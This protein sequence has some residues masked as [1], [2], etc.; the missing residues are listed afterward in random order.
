VTTLEA[1]AAGLAIPP[2]KKHK[3]K[4]PAE[5]AAFL[6]H[7]KGKAMNKVAIVPESQPEIASIDTTE[8]TTDAPEP[9]TDATEPTTDA[10]EAANDANEAVTDA[11]DADDDNQGSES[12]NETELA[13]TGV[14]N[15]EVDSQRGSDGGDGGDVDRRSGSEGGE[16]SDDPPND[17]PFRPSRRPTS[18]GSE[19]EDVTTA[20]SSSRR[21]TPTPRRATNRRRKTRATPS[22]VRTGP[23]D[24]ARDAGEKS[25]FI[26]AVRK[27][28]ADI[29]PHSPALPP[30]IYWNP[31]LTYSCA[32]KLIARTPELLEMSRQP[33]YDRPN[34]MAKKWGQVV[35]TAA[36]NERSAQIRVIKNI[37]LKSAQLSFTKVVG[38]SD[39]AQVRLSDLVR[40]ET[41]LTSVKDLRDLIRSPRMYTNACILDMFCLGIES[42]HFK[43]TTARKCTTISDML[44]PSHEAH[45]RSEIW[46]YLPL[47]PGGRHTIKTNHGADRI[48]AW[49]EFLPLVKQDRE[50]NE[51]KAFMNRAAKYGPDG[52]NAETEPDM[53]S[54]IDQVDEMFW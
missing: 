46:F 14:G 37:W 53:E 18:D 26:A 36:N 13:V 15:A 16:V 3:P 44:T 2:R 19:P 27:A 28:F 38:D 50:D 34:D 47:P 52:E 22:Y 1:V 43:Y 21:A 31:D 4:T 35:R 39:S 30:F 20:T 25:L 40:T 8:A 9:T 11:I 12:E 10:T 17:P 23:L 49:R 54:G 5:T 24:K 6:K 45:F 29:G 7:K 41:D 32:A 42:G 51:A 33:C 48:A